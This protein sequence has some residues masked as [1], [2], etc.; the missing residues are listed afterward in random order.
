MT[1]ELKTNQ[2]WAEISA[3][4]TEANIKAADAYRAWKDALSINT[5][6]LS[7]QVANEAY[8][9]RAEAYAEYKRCHD[10]AYRLSVISNSLYVD[11]VGTDDHLF[12]K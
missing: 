9:K 6:G 11:K 1:D 4:R 7:D 8:V 10:E 12:N 5:L 3:L 2:T